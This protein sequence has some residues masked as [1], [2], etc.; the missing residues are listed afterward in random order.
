[1]ENNNQNNRSRK[2]RKYLPIGTVVLIRNA[3]KRVMITGFCASSEKDGKI[4]K[5]DYCG[6]VYPEGV[7]SLNKVCLFN[8]NQISKIFHIGLINNEEKRFKEKLKYMV[9]KDNQTY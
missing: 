8:H 2:Y 9:S 1:M 4:T 5:Y 3:K 7:V 6:V